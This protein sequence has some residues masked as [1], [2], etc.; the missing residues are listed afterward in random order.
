MAQAADA[1]VDVTAGAGFG[2]L[3]V[4][5]DRGLVDVFGPKGG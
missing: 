3:L 4:P 2:T 1:A 5:T